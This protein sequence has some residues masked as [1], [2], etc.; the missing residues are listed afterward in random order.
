MVFVYP[1]HPTAIGKTL[2]LSFWVLLGEG[3]GSF[4]EPKPQK[5]AVLLPVPH[6]RRPFALDETVL[7]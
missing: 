5:D 1:L 4:S 6:G 3:T 7:H 2:T